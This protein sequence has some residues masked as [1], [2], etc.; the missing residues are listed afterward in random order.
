MCMKVPVRRE[1]ADT[2]LA[3]RGATAALWKAEG[4]GES[5][6]VCSQSV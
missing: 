2:V 6:E 1:Y 3:T 4:A 5:E